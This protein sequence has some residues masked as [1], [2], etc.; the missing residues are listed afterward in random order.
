MQFTL[1]IP[2]FAATLVAAAPS[3]EPAE[4]YKRADIY[5]VDCGGQQYARQDVQAAFNSLVAAG[6]PNA[7]KPAAGNR[8]YPRQYGDNKAMPSDT[9]VVTALNAIPGCE[10]GQTGTKYFEF[11]LAD[12]VWNGGAQGSQ[13]P[14]RVIAIAPNVGQGQTR[15]YTYCVSITHRGGGGQ[16][17]GS[18]RACQNI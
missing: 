13:G 10:A 2:L 18:F 6:G 15:S 7:Q 8:A 17:D 3:N 1:L 14:D 12:P 11:P 9:E 5:A 4:L 16:G